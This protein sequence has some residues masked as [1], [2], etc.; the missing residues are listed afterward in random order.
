M[1]DKRTEL[2]KTKDDLDFSKKLMEQVKE[3]NKKLKQE[4][5]QTMKGL[6]ESAAQTGKDLERARNRQTKSTDTVDLVIQ[7]PKVIS[8]ESVSGGEDYFE[9]K[10]RI[11]ELEDELRRVGSDK[12]RSQTD[13]GDHAQDVDLRK[14][15]DEI[16]REQRSL[17]EQG[18][19]GDRI[20]RI[21]ALV[22]QFIYGILSTCCCANHRT[23][24]EDGEDQRTGQTIFGF[25]CTGSEVPNKQRQDFTWQ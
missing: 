17:V 24:D 8:E 6:L 19:A 3:E 14:L 20:R 16:Q 12:P 18:D 23:L 7:R 22:Y 11:R 4:L 1:E 10:R 2:K 9:M 25:S 21:Q 13:G 5:D 15:L